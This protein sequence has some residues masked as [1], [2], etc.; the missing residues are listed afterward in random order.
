MAR[1]GA[2]ATGE[3]RAAWRLDV[4]LARPW[5]EVRLPGPLRCLSWA[6]AGGGVVTA[7]RVLWREVRDADLTEDLD[8][9]AWLRKELAARC[10][11]GAVG[12]L[13]SRN[14]ARY[15]LAEAEADGVRAACC[16]TVGL[17]NAERVGRRRAAA[18]G[19]WG[20]INLVC[21]TDAALTQAAQIEA[22]S[23]AVQA[24][25]TAVTEAGHVV[26]TG[27]ATGTGTDCIVLACPPG[28]TPYAGTHTAVGEAVGR[29]VW[30]SVRAGVAEWIATGGAE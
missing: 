2:E 22:L 14:V 16:A 27:V 21:A 10:A 19:A 7:A 30:E 8:A 12:L 11:A 26:E 20:T 18:A 17:T 28:A 29:A 1:E 9:A 25:T 6:P 23:V 5:L 24:R 15:R 4:A 13:T 3:T